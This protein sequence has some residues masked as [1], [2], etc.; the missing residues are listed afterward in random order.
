MSENIEEGMDSTSQISQ[1]VKALGAKHDDR[2][3]VPETHILEGKKFYKLC[4]DLPI[5]TIV[6]KHK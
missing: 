4:S 1:G 6:Y 2:H 5:H 3:S